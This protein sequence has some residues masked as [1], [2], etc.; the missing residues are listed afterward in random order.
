LFRRIGFRSC[1]MVKGAHLAILLEEADG[2]YV[3]CETCCTPAHPDT[4]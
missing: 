3:S 2:G 1:S 4:I